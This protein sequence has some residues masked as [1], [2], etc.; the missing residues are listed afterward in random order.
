MDENRDSITIVRVG[1]AACMS[2]P[3]IFLAKGKHMDVP[4]LKHLEKCGAPIG[5]TIIMTPSAYMTDKAR[6]SL[7]LPLAKG[8]RA[9]EVS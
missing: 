3:L 9:M 6:K 4:A 8:I 1:N 7:A 2:G 5:S